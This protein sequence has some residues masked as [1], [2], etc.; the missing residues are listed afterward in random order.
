MSLTHLEQNAEGYVR[1]LS[2]EI[3]NRRVGSPGNREATNFFAA[4]VRAFGFETQAQEF[5]CIDWTTAGAS[6]DC[7]GEPYKVQPSP[8]TLGG[9]F[10]ASLVVASHLSEL[11]SLEAGG[12]LLLLLGELCKEQLMPKNFTFYNPEEHQRL[13]ALLERKAPLAI[14]AA[15]SQDPGMAGAVSP[16][17][18]IEDGDF[19]IPSVYMSVEEGA[20]LAAHSDR[21]AALEIEARRRP[22][23]GCNII[24]RKGVAGEP[25]VV[26]FAHIDA[27]DGTPGAIDNA[28]GV[29]TLLLLAEL[30]AGYSGDLGVELVALNGEDYYSA[31]GETL[32]VAR[33]VGLWEEVVLGINIDGAGFVRGDTAYSL[34]GCPPDITAA[35]RDACG[36]QEGMAAGEPWYQSDHSLFLMHQRPALAITSGLFAEIWSRYAHTPDDL[37]E[38]VEARKLA[39]TALAL[40][41]LIEALADRAA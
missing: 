3:S 10:Q 5:E 23:T 35:V 25:R 37:P 1:K 8:Y 12:R 22:A 13:V 27:K 21:T 17:P 41:D 15:T 19:D 30:L 18:L 39:R 4:R 7:G 29:A 24:A 40:R 26:V 32:Y 38:I 33:N 2:L 9:R 28:S 31:P 6:L 36:G 34:Y 16:F 14:L 11:E 20:R